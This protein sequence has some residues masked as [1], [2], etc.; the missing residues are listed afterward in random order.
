MKEQKKSTSKVVVRSALI[1]LL[2]TLI[3]GCFLGSTFARYV[4]K[5]EGD[6]SAGVAEWKITETVTAGEGGTLTALSLFTPNM[7]E[8]SSAESPRS[9]KVENLTLITIK[10]DG[11][12]A[13]YVSVS[14]GSD[15]TLNNGTGEIDLTSLTNKN[16]GETNEY[17]PTKD[18]SNLIFT[19][20]TTLTYGQASGN[21][22]ESPAGGE[23]ESGEYDNMYL[24][25]PGDT[26]T[27]T[28]TVTWTTDIQGDPTDQISGFPNGVTVVKADMRDTWIGENVTSIGWDYTWYAIQAEE[29][30]EQA[31]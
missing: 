29:L 27:V 20:T 7:T 24:L 16:A 9:C 25:Y 31:P 30:P 15:V 26:L 23:Q 2:L 17:A 6:L 21:N 10:N 19:L 8:Y 18:E 22:A 12:V 5:G 4:S 11:D 3:S 14:V 1:L 28:G 13:A